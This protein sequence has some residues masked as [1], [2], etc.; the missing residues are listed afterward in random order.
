MIYWLPFDRWLACCFTETP[1][2]IVKK[3]ADVRVEEGSPVTLECEFSRQNVEVKWFKVK[4][5]QHR[6]LGRRNRLETKWF[7]TW[8]AWPQSHVN[9]DLLIK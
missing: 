7:S 4:R 6:A 2:S 9:S 8:V 3:L 5:G 1:V